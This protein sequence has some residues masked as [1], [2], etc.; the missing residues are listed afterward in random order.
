MTRPD[1]F[2]MPRACCLVAT[3]DFGF[4]NDR[5]LKFSQQS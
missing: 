5:T 2:S 1:I 3:D 4:R